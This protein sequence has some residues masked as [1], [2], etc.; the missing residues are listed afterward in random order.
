MRTR[1]R[2]KEVPRYL[3]WAM[4]A[5]VAWAGLS[6]AGCSPTIEYAVVDAQGQPIRLDAITRITG[7]VSLSEDQK[8]QKLRDLGITDQDIIEL[9]IR[10]F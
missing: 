9:L 3:A 5:G 1:R 2:W 8:R 4:A 6:P 10:N 7:D